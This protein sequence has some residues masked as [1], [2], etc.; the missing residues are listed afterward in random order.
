IQLELPLDAP[1]LL[2]TLALSILAG[3]LFGLA[4]AL[5]AT[6]LQPVDGLKRGLGSANPGS[7]RSGKVL[8]AAQVAVC[9]LIV[10][11]SGLLLR[12]VQKLE[13]V[14]IGFHRDHLLLFTVRPGLNGYKE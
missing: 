10:T 13:T 11:S 9:L 3:I 12:T 4:P 6:R 8:V 7:S 14:D 5:R 1:V 2:F